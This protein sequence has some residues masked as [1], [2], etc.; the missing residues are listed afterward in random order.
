MNTCEEFE[1]LASA[2]VDG[3]VTPVERT[4][5]FNHLAQ[6]ERCA[7][8]FFSAITIQFACAKEGMTPMPLN[9]P[10]A[11]EHPLHQQNSHVDGV[12]TRLMR[13]PSRARRK[14][15]S[16]VRTAINT[17]ISI[18]APILGFFAVMLVIV[19]FALSQP[20]EMVPMTPA[21][22]QLSGEQALLRLPV[23]RIP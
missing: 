10:A 20:A 18:P 6:C 3:E 22:Q 1:I 23:V 21:V 14:L 13:E 15:R 11:I 16:I 5:L 17:R 19:I 8:F 4:I 7:A 9:V 2:A 12:G